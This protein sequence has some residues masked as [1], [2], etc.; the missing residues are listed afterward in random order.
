MV[1]IGLLPNPISKVHELGTVKLYE[2]PSVRMVAIVDT[3]TSLEFAR[4]SLKLEGLTTFWST[5]F[6]EGLALILQE[7][8]QIVLLDLPMSPSNGLEA[9]DRILN[10][11]HAIDVL[12]VTAHTETAVAAIQKGASHYL[13]KPLSIPA[14]LGL[15]KKILCDIREKQRALELGSELIETSGFTGV[16]GRSPLMWELVARIRRFAPHY[17]SALIT[18]DTGTGKDLVAKALHTLSPAASGRFVTCNCS[19]VAETLFE[20]E[21]FGYVK[22]AFTGAAADKMGLFEFAHRGTLFL[23]E[24]GDMPLNTQA[25][26]LRTLQN[27]E[28][29]RVGSVTPRRLDVRVIA[30]TNRNVEEM[31]VQKQFRKDLYY[32]LSMVELRTPTLVD[33]RADLP[34]LEKLLLDRFSKEFNKNIRGL[35]LRAQSVLSRHSWPGNIRELENVLGHACMMAV[36]DMIDVQDLPAS[37]RHNLPPEG[38]TAGSSRQF[39]LVAKSVVSFD[40]HEKELLGEAL[41]RTSGNQSEAARMLGISRDRLRYKMAKYNLR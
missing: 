9:L 25:K 8:P 34:L 21:L 28:V 3:L 10:F 14:L 22:G 33:R 20:S 38:A 30:A 29:T 40:D 17:R 4:E 2:L 36:G 37:L 24:I 16:I 27:H 32:R 1:V 19:A 35:T 15:V 12:L 26:L 41:Y 13:H 5:N 11:D 23:D 7:H 31:I 6:E 18:G 39:N